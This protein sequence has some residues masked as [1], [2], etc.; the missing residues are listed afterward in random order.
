MNVGGSD[1]RSRVSTIRQTGPWNARRAADLFSRLRR[2][3][4]AY[5]ARRERHRVLNRLARTAGVAEPT[6][7]LL[8]LDA[9]DS[10]ARASLASPWATPPPS[11]TWTP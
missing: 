2:R 10:R 11:T 9:D 4:P 1:R 3:C 5:A 7:V 8:A 6:H